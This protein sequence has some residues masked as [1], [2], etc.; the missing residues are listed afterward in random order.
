MIK[1]LRDYFIE[2]Q[3]NNVGIGHFN[4]CTADQL[5]AI[6]EA[7]QEVGVPVMVGTSEG[8][9]EYI[10][11]RQAVALVRS[12]RYS[13]IPIFLNADHHKS[14]DSI[15]DCIDS[16]Y[17][18]VLFDGSS[19]EIS[20]NIA[21]TR[22]VVEY[23]RSINPDM[24]IEAELGYLRGKSEIQKT[25]PISLSDFTKP[26]MALDFVNQTKIDRLAVVIGNIHGIVTDQE[27]KI[28]QDALRAIKHEIPNIHLVLHGAS[29][30]KDGD[31]R[32]AILNGITNI[33]INTE[34]RIVYH[35]ALI[36]TIQDNKLETTPYKYLGPSYKAMKDLVAYKL[37][38]FAGL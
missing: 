10:G 26:L 4:F 7:S 37:K 21:V 23:A 35:D 5:R 15:K 24:M 13:G 27:E 32:T 1:T 29:G 12:Y 36:K 33:H 11:R 30:L 38:L 18:T 16:G 8:E 19:L 31:V 20:E 28:D 17:D 14:F 6:A 2:A 25:V 22:K 34:C 9:A 3:R